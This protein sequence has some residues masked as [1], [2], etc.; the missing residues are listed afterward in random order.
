VS[1]IAAL[2][3]VLDEAGSPCTWDESVGGIRRFFTRDPWGNRLEFTEQ[4]L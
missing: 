4:R 2:F 3:G 1:D